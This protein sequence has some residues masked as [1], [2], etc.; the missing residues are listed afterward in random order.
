M[1]N[2]KLASKKNRPTAQ[3]VVP[4][5]TDA[6]EDTQVHQVPTPVLSK[7][8][9]ETPSSQAATSQSLARSYATTSGNG[10]APTL[11]VRGIANVQDFLNKISHSSTADDHSLPPSDATTSGNG[12]APPVRGIANVRA[13][14]NKFS[15]SS[16]ADDPE[17]ESPY[18]GRNVTEVPEPSPLVADPHASQ[19]GAFPVDGI[20]DTSQTRTNHTPSPVP[21]PS[22]Q[23]RSEEGLTQSEEREYMVP[24]ATLV[25]QRALVVAEIVEPM[26]PV[27]PVEKFWRQRKVQRCAFLLFLA[28]AGLTVGLAV[29]LGDAAPPFKCFDTTFELRGAVDSYLFDNSPESRVASNY[30]HPIGDLFTVSPLDTLL[31]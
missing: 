16:T 29:G 3:T 5:S 28:A 26:E 25:S 15:H 7:I 11:N 1:Q 30:G 4:N 2:S 6:A 17:S 8:S 10:N 9:S 20:N 22:T 18:Q 23:S 12:N 13:Y 31:T 19:P 21:V 24:E 27:E 14:L